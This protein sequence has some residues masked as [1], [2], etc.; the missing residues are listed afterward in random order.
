MASF[1]SEL[2]TERNKYKDFID[3]NAIKILHFESDLNT[4][5]QIL[6][7]LFK[8]TVPSS[9]TNLLK[10]HCLACLLQGF[11]WSKWCQTKPQRSCPSTNA[12]WVACVGACA[13]MPDG[14]YLNAS[15]V[16]LI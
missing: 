16:V 3:Q 13:G 4:I 5:H 1:V 11:D 14:G 2:S 9:V 6:G 8:D 15:A 10:K 12:N 7:P